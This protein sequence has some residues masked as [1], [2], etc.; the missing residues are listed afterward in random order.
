MAGAKLDFENGWMGVE[1]CEGP[2]GKQ[3][4]MACVYSKSKG[5]RTSSPIG[6]EQAEQFALDVMKQVCF[7]RGYTEDDII[8]VGLERIVDE[9]RGVK[10]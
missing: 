1:R 5:L 3:F 2:D 6:L 9:I 8:N 10:G 4:L 7:A